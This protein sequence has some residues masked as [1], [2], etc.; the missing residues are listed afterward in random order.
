MKYDY[1]VWDFNGTIIDDRQLCLDI[2]NKMLIEH[3]VKTVTMEEYREVF[4]FPVI[5]YYRKV[6]FNF[7]LYPF[8]VLAVEFIELY[9]KNSLS[10]GLV[11]NSEETLRKIKELGYHQIILSASEKNN[12][13]EQIKHYHLE[14]YFDVILGL[15]DIHATSKE[16]LALDWIKTLPNKNPKLLVVGDSLHDYEVS[17]VLH[18]DC[19]LIDK[20]SHQ[21]K[22][23]LK[24][25]GCPVLDT[26]L[27]IIDFL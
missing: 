19:L 9:Q 18:A 20:G 26:A 17:K 4:G 7:D 25:T 22:E 8:S 10:V 5:D 3:G 23:R 14:N 1:I 21:S 12:L 6:G 2:L 11:Q 24:K 16:A 15:G 27:D 13:D